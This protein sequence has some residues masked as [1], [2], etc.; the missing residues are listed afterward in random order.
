MKNKIIYILLLIIIIEGLFLVLRPNLKSIRTDSGWDTDYSSDSSWDSSSDYSWDND[1]DYD[2]SSGSGGGADFGPLGNAIILEVIK[3]IFFIALVGS[4]V[5]KNKKNSMLIAFLINL[6]RF[7]VMVVSEYYISLYVG[8]CSIILISLLLFPWCF[9]MAVISI[10]KGLFGSHKKV[11]ESH[12]YDWP[13]EK[14]KKY[15]VDSPEDLKKKL[16]DIFVKVQMAWMEFDYDALSKLCSNELYNSYKSD[17]EVLKLKNGKNIMD[18][19]KENDIRIYN[20]KKTDEYMDVS[21]YLDVTFHDYVIDTTNDKVIRGDKKKIINNQYKLVYRKYLHKI[22]KCPS[23]GA[24]I[25]NN[26]NKCSHCGNIIIN[27]S[28]D[29]V[30]ISKGRV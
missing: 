1:R 2:Y 4:L 21:I 10:F 6:P 24:S 3:S 22:D 14:I 15:G 13:K 16:Y 23:C 28:N 11:Y 7:I 29:Y 17:L 20:I 25:K 19:F 5:F 8:Y 27:N 18:S 30:L 12:Y 26:S 9:Y